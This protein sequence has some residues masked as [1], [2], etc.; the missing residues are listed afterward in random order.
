MRPESNRSNSERHIHQLLSQGRTLVQQARPQ[1]AQACFSQ[2]LALDPDRVETLL[3]LAALA[4]D[5]R[6]S[7]AYLQRV[8]TLS[9]GHPAT[10]AG[11]R[12]AN[13]RLLARSPASPPAQAEPETPNASQS[14]TLLPSRSGAHWLDTMLVSG[15]VMICI[16]ACVILTV[17]AWEAPQAVRAA[18]RPT[19]SFSPSQVAALPPVQT[20][21]PTCTGTLTPTPAPTATATWTP[22][23]TEAPSPTPSPAA[24]PHGS[25]S[26][27]TGLEEKWIDIDLSEQKLVAYEGDTLVYSALVSTG[28]PSLPTPAGRYKILRK[29]RSQVMS[30][31]GYYLPNVEFVSY[32]FKGYAIHGTYW[33]SNFGH[34]MSHG[35]VNMRNEDA[36]WI[37]EWGPIGTPVVVHQ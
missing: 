33:H 29:I 37:Y 9:P 34:P 28:I 11:L 30:G 18:Y 22:T 14:R 26:L 12:W 10:A 16:A 2:A 4:Q 35:C 21:V 24:V 20:P 1:D 25:L 23:P 36:R 5:P 17:M 6:Q 8:Q 7:I 15:I 27:S 13:K 31:P 19:A 32:F 3:W